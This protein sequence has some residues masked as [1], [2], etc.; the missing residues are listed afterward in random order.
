[1]NFS[2]FMKLHKAIKNNKVKMDSDYKFFEYMLNKDWI[3][4]I[5]EDVEP[6]SESNVFMLNPSYSE[7]VKITD[8]GKDIYFKSRNT[9]IKWILGTIISISTAITVALLRLLLV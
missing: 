1:M 3:S 2:M 4:L 7:Y 8:K 5:I 6:V 9:W